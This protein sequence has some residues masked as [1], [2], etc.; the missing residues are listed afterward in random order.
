MHGGVTNVHKPIKK[1]GIEI[2]CG[3]YEELKFYVIFNI[4]F[5]FID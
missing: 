3:L 5:I 4:D 2:I 1:E